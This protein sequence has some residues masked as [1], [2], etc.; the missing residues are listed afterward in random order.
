MIGKI[1]IF[2]PF[3]AQTKNAVK[4]SANF[5]KLFSIHNFEKFAEYIYNLRGYDQRVDFDMNSLAIEPRKIIAGIFDKEKVNFLE[6]KGVEVINLPI[7]HRW[8][9]D[10]GIHCYTN[11]VERA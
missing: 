8:V 7:R 6:S 1:R 9:I 10:G 11:D 4:E 5:N 3:D 2:I